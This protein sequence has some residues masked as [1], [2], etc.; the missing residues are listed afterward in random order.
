MKSLDLIELCVAM[1]MWKENRRDGF[2]SVDILK[3]LYKYD[4]SDN[5]QTIILNRILMAMRSLKKDE[6]VKEL[7]MENQNK[8]V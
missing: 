1:K 8:E 5:D 7:L 6:A 3:E 4:V 2:L